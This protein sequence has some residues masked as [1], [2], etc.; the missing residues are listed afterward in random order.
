MTKN[1]Q[2]NLVQFAFQTTELFG[3][4]NPLELYVQWI[5]HHL[6]SRVLGASENVGFWAS[7]SRPNTN[8]FGSKCIPI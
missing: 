1:S 8:I 5:A 3:Y 7:Q 6:M 4:L 2:L